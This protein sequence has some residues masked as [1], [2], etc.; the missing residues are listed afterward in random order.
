M[1]QFIYAGPSWAV[2]SYPDDL[3]PKTSLLQEWNLSAISV[4]IK[5]SSNFGEVS[6]IKKLDSNLPVIFLYCEPLNDLENITGLTV[7]D[8]IE[9][10]NWQEIWHECNTACLNAID[11]LDNPVALI[12]AHSDVVNNT[13]NSFVIESSWQKWIA[14]QANMTVIDDIINVDPIDGGSYPLSKCWGAEVIHRHL[15]ANP[16]FK[17]HPSLL[18]AIWDI[19]FFWEELQRRGWFFEVHPNYIANVEFAHYTQQTIVDFLD[20]E[21]NNNVKILS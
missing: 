13:T 5:A 3:E 2:T 10:E 16:E 19:Y 4:A 14:Q 8:F 11:N 7:R 1:T 17:P 15:H 6:K 21:G 9:S 18:D 20:R 12:G